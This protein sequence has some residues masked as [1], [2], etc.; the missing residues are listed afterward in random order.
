MEGGGRPKPSPLTEELWILKVVPTPVGGPACIGIPQTGRDG[1]LKES[2][3][4]GNW[5]NIVV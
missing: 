1:L 2:E 5:R 4:L 3:R